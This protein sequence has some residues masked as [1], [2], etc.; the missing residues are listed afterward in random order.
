MMVIEMD[1]LRRFG[2]DL[3]AAADEKTVFALGVVVGAFVPLLVL[4]IG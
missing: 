2:T 1:D 4:A 3:E